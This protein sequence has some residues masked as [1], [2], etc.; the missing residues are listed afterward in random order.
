[1]G[2]VGFGEENPNYKH[3]LATR[4]QRRPRTYRIWQGMLNRCRNKKQKTWARYGG[5]GIR[6]CSEWVEYAAFLAD[7]GEAP[8]G[9]TLDRIDNDDNY[10]KNNCR[11]ATRVEQRRNSPQITFVTIGGVSK[12]SWEWMEELGLSR[13]QVYALGKDPPGRERLI[14]FKGKTLSLSQWAEKTGYSI[15][16]IHWRLAK[17][18]SIERALTTPVKGKK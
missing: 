17:S 9:L 13:Q 8:A 5:R 6:V 2:V 3:G 1:M 12:R 7:M 14:V 15:Q 4:G 10:Y 11:W 18:W 16:T